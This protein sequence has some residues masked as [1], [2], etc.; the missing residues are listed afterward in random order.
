MKILL[1]LHHPLNIQAGA[2]GATLQLGL[3]YQALG[4][5]VEYY[6]FD[7]APVKLPELMQSLVFPSFVARHL[8]KVAT[9]QTIDVIDASTGDAW[10]WAR[11]F[12]TSRQP[13]P[14]LVTRSHG[15][16]HVAH[17]ERMEDVQ[18]GN[19][20]LSWKYPLYHGGWRLW[21]V[22][23]S[24][25]SADRVLLLNQRD[26]EYA[27]QQLGIAPERAHIVHNGIPTSFLNQPY[28]PL[29]LGD[30]IRIAQ[31]GSYIPRK[32]IAY[33]TPALNHLLQAYPQVKV[34]FFGTGCP[35]EQV[36]QE[37]D[38]DVRDRVQV[39]PRFEH[40]Q[41]P[42][43]LSN[44]HIKLFPTLSE[45]F[46]LALTEAMAC[47][48][49]PVTTAT[50]GPLEIARHADNA[51]VIPARNTEAIVQALEALITNITYLNQLRYS[52]HA[53]AQTYSWERIALENL[54]IY[55]AARRPLHPVQTHVSTQLT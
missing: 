23:Q 47:G 2:P 49:A 40:G 36:W 7:Q 45:G 51:I 15:L 44:Y 54:A 9:Q 34:G 20:Q 6:T 41:L 38:S 16:E 19:L 3:A 52:A 55:E 33:G 22:A 48:L 11:F 39:L 12:R 17:S 10:L 53:T 43:L 18:R 35:P 29:Q 32:G 50:P 46:S 30:P 31:V 14:L 25:R 24:M 26:R 28:I 5:E 37:F 42:K 21:E 1:T 4:H 13:A 8:A 27:I